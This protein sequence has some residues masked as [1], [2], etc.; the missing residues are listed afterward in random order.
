MIKKIISGGQTGADQAAL[1]AAVQWRI[2]HGGWIAKGRLT[3][4]GRLPDKYKLTEMP[5]KSYPKRTEQN[6]ID[7]DGTLIISHGPLTGGSQDTQEAAEGH[8]KPCLHVDLNNINSFRAAYAVKKWVA[9]NSIETLNVAGPRLSKD[10][11]IY[12]PTLRILSTL[13]QMEQVESGMNPSPAI[14][15]TVEDVVAILIDELPLKKKTQI[16]KMKESDLILLH[17]TLGEYISHEFLWNGNEQLIKDC[18][19]K[20]GRDVMDEDGASMIILKELWVQLRKS[21]RLRIVK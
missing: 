2:P 16:A 21:H 14:L 3:E 12:T 13:F 18:L 15:E 9:D 10:K 4:A 19:N 7:S 11:Y 1:D 20:S 6:V 5:S 17:P 8:N